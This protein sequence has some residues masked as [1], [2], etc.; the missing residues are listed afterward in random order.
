LSLPPSRQL[1]PADYVYDGLGRPRV[2]AAV[3]VQVQPEPARVLAVG[4]APLMRAQY[5]EVPVRPR[6]RVIAPA[7]VNAHTHLDLSD[8]PLTA[9]R[10]VDFVQRVV[11]FGRAGGRGLAAA[12]RGLAELR[13]AGVEVVGDIVTDEGVLG[14]LL[15]DP[16]LRGVAY[17]EVLG[18]DPAAVDRIMAEVEGVVR[19]FRPLERPGGVRL[20]LSPHAPHTLSV[21]LWRRLTALARA[22]G[23]PLQIH[24]A[25][26]AAELQLHARGEGPL[27]EA[28]GPF[29]AAFVP[30]G[31]T[32]VAYLDELGVLA[33]RPTLV[34]AVHVDEDDLR[35]LQRAGCVVVHCP[36]SNALLQSGTF[37][38][39]AYAR[40]GVSVALGT[41]S[42]ASSPSLSPV[43]EWGA[44]VA[45][46][47]V[48]ADPAQLLWSAV[49]G[50]YRALGGEPPRVTR[51]SLASGLR[52]WPEA[53]PW[54]SEPG[55]RAAPGSVDDVASGPR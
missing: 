53:Q 8:M 5:P 3:L 36:R 33:A 50:G 45:I 47:G 17:W 42:R 37:P 46:H 1:W 30:S 34:H 22:Q 48:G 51:G 23:L 9:G 2:D 18:P 13:T 41:D 40:H 11:A 44:A 19:R 21:P 24:V 28:F 49:K 43:D 52:S 26:D 31:R 27:R 25:E 32:P 29:L 4:A 54:P 38:W 35:R 14:R 15:Q 20:G 16:Q 12:E 6:V 7:P 39:S 10:Y 55:G